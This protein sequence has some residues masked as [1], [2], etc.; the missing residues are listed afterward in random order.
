MAKAKNKNSGRWVAFLR[1]V[2]VG[3][4]TAKSPQLVA[5]FSSLGFQNVSTF[6]A[7]GN[8]VFDLDGHKTTELRKLIE[9]RLELDLGFLTEPILR[10]MEDVARIASLNPFDLTAQ[11]QENYTINVSL[12]DKE[13]PKAIRDQV[14]VLSSSY[15]D[16]YFDKLEMYWLCRGKKISVSPLFENNKLAKA[17]SVT[18]TMRNQ[19]TMQRIVEKF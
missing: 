12:F 4:R 9:D 15:D 14:A 2:N 8:V 6:L 13:P 11:E 16:F 10:S 18:N 1:A 17:L 5:S 19:R 3:K 7:S